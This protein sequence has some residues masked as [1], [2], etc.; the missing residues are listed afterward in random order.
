MAI[1]PF[2]FSRHVNA[3]SAQVT[4]ASRCVRYE[5]SSSANRFRVGFGGKTLAAGIATRSIDSFPH[6]GLVRVGG[7]D[8]EF[9]EIEGPPDSSG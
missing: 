5:G 7:E 3:A 1:G 6:S 9:V 4:P 8:L 2:E